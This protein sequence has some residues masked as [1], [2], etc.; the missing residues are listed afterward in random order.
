MRLKR[1]DLIFTILAG[2]A[3]GLVLAIAANWHL[4]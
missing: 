2:A 3:A 4:W 1:R